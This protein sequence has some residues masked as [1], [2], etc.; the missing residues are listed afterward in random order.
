MEVD[1]GGRGTI[2]V[3]GPFVDEPVA[4]AVGYG[5]S[6]T[7]DRTVLVVDIGGG[8]MHVVLVRLSAH[9]ALRG[10]AGVLAKR[11]RELGGN[12]VDCF[13]LA[14]LCLEM[15][16]PLDE[17]GDDEA[18][19]LWR[20]LMLAE[21]CR[22][23]EAVFFDESAEFLRKAIIG[24]GEARFGAPFQFEDA[25]WVSFRLAEILPLRSDVKQKLLELH[26]AS[27][28]LAILHRFLR[29]QKLIA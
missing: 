17:S 11:G 9:G 19:R 2:A 22:V 18:A 6:L 28:R 13:V 20:R 29:Q 14:D 27:V 15:G 10:Q 23:K 4:A 8:T 25:S 7:E 5:L 26:D 3:G 21:A 1:L 24:I 16:Q 12:A